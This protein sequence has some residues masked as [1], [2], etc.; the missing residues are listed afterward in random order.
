M[1]EFEEP[2]SEINIIKGIINLVYSGCLLLFFH[3]FLAIGSTVLNAL[4]Y[5]KI[6][7]KLVQ[8]C[9]RISEIQ[10]DIYDKLVSLTTSTCKKN[11]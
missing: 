5:L 1:N 11:R 3:L 8:I 6:T 10:T 9:D 7:G 2:V 4:D